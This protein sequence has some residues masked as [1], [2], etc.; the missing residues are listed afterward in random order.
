MCSNY[1]GK[2]L[3]PAL[4]K[5]D[6]KTEHLSSYMVPSSTQPQKQSF[7]VVERTRTSTRCAK[8]KNARA[9]SAKL[10]FFTVKYANLWRSCCRRCRGCLIKLL[11]VQLAQL[12]GARAKFSLIYSHFRHNGHR[13]QKISQSRIKPLLIL[14]KLFLVVFKVCPLWENGDSKIP[15]THDM[16][17][18]QRRKYQ[19][20]VRIMIIV[21]C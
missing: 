11:I 18:F 21:Y 12:R 5:L 16:F 13:M 3:E 6:D 7:H 10:L 9:K 4:Q 15:S 19:V 1:P 17:W 8:T 14:G 2:K 20:K